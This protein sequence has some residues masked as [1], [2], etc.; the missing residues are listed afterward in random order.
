MPEK[1]PVKSTG[2]ITCSRPKLAASCFLSAFPKAW[3]CK[4]YLGHEPKTVQ[5]KPAYLA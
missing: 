1:K 3:W 2:Q 4:K 5:P